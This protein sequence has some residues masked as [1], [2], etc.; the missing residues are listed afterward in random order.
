MLVF[1]AG[2][3]LGVSL[4]CQVS[5]CLTGTLL[6]GGATVCV[7]D[8]G[9]RQF[10]LTGLPTHLQWTW[11][12]FVR[13]RERERESGGGCRER[14]GERNE[15]GV[16]GE[17]GSER[18]RD[19]EREGRGD[20]DRESERVETQ[21]G[22]GG[23]GFREKGGGGQRERKSGDSVNSN[24]KTLFYMDCSLGSIKN[25]TTSPWEREGREDSERGDSEGGGGGTHKRRERELFGD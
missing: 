6:W 12:S 24:S 20:S 9:F 11:V 17:G 19:L 22:G 15:V 1:K 14:E 25:L 4:S 7:W 3:S 8:L 18:E 13:E 23:G 21:I 10:L 5:H 16:G 2:L